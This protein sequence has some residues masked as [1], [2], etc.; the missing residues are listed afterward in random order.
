MEE[1]WKSGQPPEEGIA[2]DYPV[3]GA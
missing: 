1:V 2:E 3:E